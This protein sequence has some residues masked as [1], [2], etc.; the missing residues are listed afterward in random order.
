MEPQRRA[1]QPVC[2]AEGK[3]ER[4]LHNWCHHLALPNLKC[5]STGMGRGWGLR[6]GLRRS[7]LGKGLGLA[8][9]R[10]PEGARVWCTI[11]QGIQEGAWARQ[12]GKAPLLGRGC[13]K[14][15]GTAIGASLST[16]ALRWQGTAYMNFR[17]GCELPLPS[18]TPEVGA[19]HCHC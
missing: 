14:R 5:P 4:D 10:Q 13:E 3:A 17:G 18:Q 2:F 8:V 1:Q 9:W 15:G 6:L 12:K 11:T 7:D 16:Q 19:D